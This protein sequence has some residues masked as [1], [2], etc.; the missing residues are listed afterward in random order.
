MMASGAMPRVSGESC[1]AFC[2][3]ART[4]LKFQP[5]TSVTLLRASSPRTS[6]L[7]SL[8]GVVPGTSS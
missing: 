5:S 6:M 4:W 8:R 7:S 3:A 1:S 2:S